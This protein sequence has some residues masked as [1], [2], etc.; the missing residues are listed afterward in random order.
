MKC[1]IGLG[2][3]GKKYEKTRHNIGFMVIDELIKRFGMDFNK[4]KFKCDYDIQEKVLF[5]KPQTFMN[6]SGE[7]VRPLLDFYKINVEDVFV[8]YDDLDLPIG[9]IRLRE[10]GGHGGHNGIK[11]LIEHLGT[12]NFKRL[13]IGIGRPTNATPIVN[14]VLQ[15]FAKQELEDVAYTIVQAADA[16][17]MWLEKPFNEVMNVYN[18]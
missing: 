11:S 13:R 10:K 8:I 3:P 4:S 12:K 1:I 15:P 9:K 5:I 18:K 7:G 14:Y 16:C 17:E 6:L 2:N